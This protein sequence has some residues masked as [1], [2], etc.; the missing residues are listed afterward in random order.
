M[1][2]IPFE[3]LLLATE[4][5]EFDRGAEAVA[6]ALALHGRLRLT[7]V[8]PMVSNA[9]FETAAPAQA[10]RADD[11]AGLRR[12]SLADYAAAA[13]VELDVRIRRGDEPHAEILAQARELPADLLVI[14]RRGK[15]GL[16]ANMLVGEMVSRVVTHAP[17]NLLIASRSARLW[18]RGVLAAVDAQAGARD[19]HVAIQAARL[20]RAFA[21]PLRIVTVVA[22]PA[23]RE[24]AQALMAQME[25]DLKAILG[26]ASLL[27]TDI[28]EGRAHDQLLSAAAHHGDDLIVIGRHTSTPRLGRAR[29][30]DTLHEVIGH[31]ECPVWICAPAPGA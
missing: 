14:R 13:G 26:A 8:L 19:I 10:A 12:A 6:F 7:A 2:P 27:N 15:R 3:R 23:Q 22:A 5:T 24:A 29:I 25:P 30:G 16:L 21:L 17:C 11:E 28:R 4:H 9:E 1:Q 18:R 20:A 31:A